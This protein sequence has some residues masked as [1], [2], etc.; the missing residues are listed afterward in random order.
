VDMYKD[1]QKEDMAL[2]GAIFFVFYVVIGALIFANMVF[3][4]CVCACVYVCVCMG[5]HLREYG[6]RY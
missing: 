2:S 4:M 6:I 1:F 3:T 5:A